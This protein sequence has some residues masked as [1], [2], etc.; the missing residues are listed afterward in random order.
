MKLTYKYR[1]KP[2]PQQ[3]IIFQSWLELARRQ[4][5]Y[6]LGERF[7]WYEATRSRVD[8]CPLV[9][10]IAPVEEIY[11][12][13]PLTR[14][15]AKGSRKGEEI[16]NFQEQGYL[17]WHSIQLSDLKQTKTLFP[18]Y[19]QLDSQ[20]LQDVVNR[21]E[22]A[23]SR[24]T[25][26]DANDNRSGKPKFKGQ[27]YYN[28]FTY[29]QLH[30]CDIIKDER[31]KNC[32]NLKKIG[33]VPFVFHRPIPDG[34]EVKT[35][36]VLREADGWHISLVLEDKSVP[37]TVAAIQPTEEN[38]LGIDLGVENYIALSTGEVVEHPRFFTESARKLE[39][40]QQRLA[41]RVKHSKPWKLL[42]VQIAKLHQHIA[43]QRLD[44]QFKLAH[45][46]FDKCDVLFIEDL[47]LK[48]LT[49][50]AKPKI[51]NEGEWLPN[52]QAAKSG[53]NRSMLDAAHGQFV[54]VLKWV[55]YKLGKV[56]KEVDPWGTSQHCWSCLNQVPKTLSDRWHS[57]ECGEECHRDENSGRLIK[58]IGLICSIVRADITSLKTAQRALLEGKPVLY[59]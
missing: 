23:F 19:K 28:S 20:V 14:V 15:L 50:R 30:N 29:T 24:F 37:V 11:R 2:L 27:H 31:G 35:G 18:D 8:A 44:W 9:V 17:N 36:T 54:Q 22:Y 7:D 3:Q 39:K 10:S 56:V 43:R 40:L 45:W 21:V 4:Y 42:K 55:A 47:K 53:L 12:D 34:F 51:S 13:I 38:S 33:L 6:R 48:N 32:V 49:K 46:L 26:P 52:G 1:L 41:K 59:A 57:C 16:S 25:K 5:N 58:K